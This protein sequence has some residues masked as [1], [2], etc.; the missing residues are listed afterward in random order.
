MKIKKFV[1]PDIRRAI[2]MVREEQG[3]DAV[4]LSNR[5]VDG[6]VEIV[7]AVDYDE[8][9]FKAARDKPEDTN[10][11]SQG[12]IAAYR[13]EA[14]SGGDD[15]SRLLA[16]AVKNDIAQ[17]PKESGLAV[18]ESALSA[19]REELKYLRTIVETRFFDLE[20]TNYSH[21]NP[22]SAEFIKSL[23]NCG[24]SSKLAGDIARELPYIRKAEDAWQ[25]GLAKLMGR[26]RIAEDDIVDGGGIV[27]LVGPTGVGKTTTVAKLA[28]RYAL[29][30]GVRHA[31]LVT[32]DNY[33]V[34]AHE[35]LR[36]Y[37]R[38]LDIPMY[39][40]SSKEDLQAHLEDLLDKNL[41]LIDTA[42]MSQR[43]MRISEQLS[44]LKGSKFNIKVYLVISATG[45]L[46]GIEEVIDVFRGVD[47]DGCIITKLDEATRVGPVVS[48]VI[49]KK[50]SVAYISDGQRVPED[51]HLA[52]A[53][54]LIN[55]ENFNMQKGVESSAEEMM[56]FIMGR[57]ARNAH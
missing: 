31:A 49:E 16:E 4:I 38:L 10:P 50:L 44:V 5:R 37:G 6:G 9:L 56:H 33:R 39:S 12:G 30:R 26:I 54:K 55:K 46:T 36:T 45:Q 34:G 8:T 22:A 29:R 25:N 18:A 42:G 2:R 14:Q 28:A 57:T 52:R 43:D 32:T 20:W 15:Y 47:L 19:T 51:L 11:T 23:L 41:I 24:I 53:D 3:P 21:N 40:A 17:G 1:A 48:A 27:A 13:A 7:S 35:Q